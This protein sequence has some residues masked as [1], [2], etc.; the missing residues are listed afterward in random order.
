MKDTG[1]VRKVEGEVKINSVSLFQFHF[2]SMTKHIFT[3][4][5]NNY[6][7]Q[8]EY[9]CYEGTASTKQL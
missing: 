2:K 1:E 8:V 9:N 3:V 6:G 5:G 4:I 7:R